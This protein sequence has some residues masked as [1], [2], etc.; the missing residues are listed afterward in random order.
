M[1]DVFIVLYV[2]CEEKRHLKFNANLN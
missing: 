2:T 1:E